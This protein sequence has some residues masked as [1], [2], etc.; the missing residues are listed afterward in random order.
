[1]QST[2]LTGK[3]FAIVGGSGGIGKA[4]CEQL[5]NLGAHPIPLSRSTPYFTIDLTSPKAIEKAFHR[6]GPLDGLINCAGFLKV[7]PLS[8]LSFEEIGTHL[9]V[10]LKGVILACKCAQIKAGGHIINIASSSF[11]RGRKNLSLYSCAKAAIIN[12]TQALSEERTELKIHSVVPQ[13]TKTQMRLENF[14]QEDPSSLLEPEEVAKAVIGLLK[15]SN[16]TGLLVE[17][18]KN[19]T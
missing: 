13:R 18:K 3:K 5:K 4:I 7:S 17:V 10:N 19:Y 15:D 9:D 12:F 8:Q 6:L 11:T 2:D 14:P 16:S 1:M